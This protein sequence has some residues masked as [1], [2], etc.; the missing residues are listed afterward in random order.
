M[1]PL[2]PQQMA[3]FRRSVPFSSL[4]SNTAAGLLRFYP[5][6]HLALQLW[7]VYV[8]AVDPVLKILHIPT[9]Q[10]AVIATILA[11]GSS[12]APMVALTFAI[13]FAAV[14]ALGH[15]EEPVELPS[16][17]SALL[18]GYKTALDQLLVMTDLMRR[19]DITSLQALAIYVVC[20]PWSPLTEI[21]SHSVHIDLFTSP[22][23]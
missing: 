2:Y 6:P 22:R 20:T 13:Y 15:F 8:R 12:G 16:E 14:T 9:T 5:D 17:R 23:S 19:P 18:S 4:P 10:S 7:S 21:R 3:G 11:P 1:N